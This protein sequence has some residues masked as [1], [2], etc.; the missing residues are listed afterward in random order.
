MRVNDPAEAVGDGGCYTCIAR[1]RRS[2]HDGGSGRT[3]E[4]FAGR[5]VGRVARLGEG[6]AGDGQQARS[7][8]GKGTGSGCGGRGAGG[9]DADGQSGGE[10]RSQFLA[11]SHRFQR[12]FGQSGGLGRGFAA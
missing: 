4:G 12:G 2:E 1:A 9:Y 3:A 6:F 5:S 10:A 8:G 11:G 7:G